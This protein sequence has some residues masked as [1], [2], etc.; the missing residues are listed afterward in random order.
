MTTE[1]DWNAAT[2]E[3]VRILREYLR[4]DTS[5]PPGNE[6]RAVRFLG[7]I[8]AAEGI[9][10]ETA[11]SAPGRSNLIARVG[12]GKGGICLLNH[13]DVVPVE[14]QFWDVD[15]FGG[16]LRD[17]MIW[18]RGALDMKAMGV[19]ELMTVILLKRQGVP[20]RRAVTFLAVADEEAGSE[21]GAAWIERHRPTWL[22]ADLVINEGAYGL[23]EIAGSGT[24]VFTF[25]P[26]EKVPF[27]LRLVT[28]GRPGHGSVPHGDNCAERLVQALD[29]VGRWQ[30]GVRVTPV[31]QAHFDALAEAGLGPGSGEA[32]IRATAGENPAAR[33]RLANTIS[34]TT[35][36]TGVK[37]NVIPA[38]ASATLDCRL[39]PDVDPDEFL[40]ALRAVIGDERVEIEVINRYQGAASPLDSEFTRVVSEVVSEMVEGARLIPELTPG[41]TDS[42]IYRMR[43]VPAYGF[44]PCV[45]P[46]GDLATIHGHNERISVENIRLGLQVM[47]EV[48]RRLCAS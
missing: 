24:P 45:L 47:Y 26:S 23:S 35:I 36:A 31:M 6:E 3:A 32:A 18:G 30:Q 28:R 39:L 12:P 8:L 17:G 38:E 40:A 48:V 37:V 34:L 46:P 14:R 2:N 7:E 27:W 33:A 19:M 4:I 15:P 21:F 43:G 29:R 9:P 41:F 5:N 1:I 13:T 20:L 25:A 42:R 10:F 11:E 22:G 44:V 16:E